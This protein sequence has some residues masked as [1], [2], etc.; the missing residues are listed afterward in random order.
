MVEKSIVELRKEFK[1]EIEDG[2][3]ECEKLGYDPIGFKRMLEGEH[4][5]EIAERFVVT[6]DVQEGFKTLI[7]MNRPDLTLEAYVVKQKYRR[8]FSSAASESARWR[9]ENSQD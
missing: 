7:K 1:E 4:P 5:V 3:N 8:L 6:A 2:N 9:L